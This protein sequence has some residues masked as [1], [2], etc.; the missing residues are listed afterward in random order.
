MYGISKRNAVRGRLLLLVAVLSSASVVLNSSGQGLIVHNSS[1]TA[2]YVKWYN[3]QGGNWAFW[4]G[5]NINAGAEQGVSSG[6]Y[7]PIKAEI[8]NSGQTLKLGE[9]QWASYQAGNRTEYW[10]GVAP[11]QYY[12]VHT[13][14]C[15]TV[16]DTYSVW[17][18]YQSGSNTVPVPS[19]HLKPGECISLDLYSEEPFTWTIRNSD[20]EIAGGG[21]AAPGTQQYGGG[22]ST[23]NTNS[24]PGTPPSVTVTNQYNYFTNYI[25]FGGT[26]L[27]T[28]E[29]FQKGIQWIGGKMDQNNA[30]LAAAIL[31]STLALSNTIYQ[32]ANRGG[33]TWN[34]NQMEGMSNRLADINLTARGTSNA[35]SAGANGV[36]NAVVGGAGAITNTL[37]LVWRSLT[38]QNDLDSNRAGVLMKGSNDFYGRM[39]VAQS[40]GLSLWNSN[41]GSAFNDYS[42]ATLGGSSVL[43]Q[44]V[45][46]VGS[47]LAVQLPGRFGKEFSIDL[48]DSVFSRIRA[49]GRTVFRF[50]SWVLVLG[51]WYACWT[52]MMD[53]SEALGTA[54]LQSSSLRIAGWQEA[55]A[56]AGFGTILAWFV[57]VG[58]GTLP[59]IGLVWLNNNGGNPF[60]FSVAADVAAN[61]VDGAGGAVTPFYIRCFYLFSD[62]IPWVLCI[63]LFIQYCLFRALAFHVFKA[64]CAALRGLGVVTG[65]LIALAA[66]N[67]DG[68]RVTFDNWTGSAV[69]CSNGAFTYAWPVGSTESTVP[70]GT[71]TNGDGRW[72]VD[73]NGFAVVGCWIGGYGP[74]GAT[75][76]FSCSATESGEGVF[77][78]GFCCGFAIF[79][80]AWTVSVVR[81]GVFLRASY[82]QDTGG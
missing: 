51:Y 62:I 71:W 52:L 31:G 64:V 22:G 69:T 21:L 53:Q 63:Q 57:A 36:S 9:F 74:L 77:W 56:R 33:G 50:L 20:W 38:N 1:A 46:G 72:T 19:V 68:A 15:A 82:N 2:I 44:A 23:G 61:G 78:T 29:E 26:N 40:R 10:N 43:T 17:L 73:A 32:N 39:N 30:A 4:T 41:G 59:A 45:A 67:A 79:G 48:A 35:V 47:R 6:S 54:S 66:L 5:F 34:T 58:L 27:L 28:I 13:N 75:N 3:T 16:E 8:W 76:A 42:N 37:G 80:F 65:C 60:T 70:S 25:G 24:P 14:W 7:Y 12:E 18:T 55:I 81:R 49:M 11:N